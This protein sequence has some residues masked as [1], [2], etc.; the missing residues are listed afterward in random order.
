MYIYTVYIYSKCYKMRK[1]SDLC[2]GYVMVML[3][4]SYGAIS[5][6]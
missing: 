4:V 2:Y 1:I 6:Y 3:R 5:T